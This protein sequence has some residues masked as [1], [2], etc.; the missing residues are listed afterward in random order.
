MID[1]MT[2]ESLALEERAAVHAAL[3]DPARLRIVDLLMLGDLSPSELM[4]RL[5]LASNLL[6]HHLKVLETAGVVARRRSDADRRRTYLRLLPDRLDPLAPG[7]VRPVSRVV[8]VCTAASA[9]SQLAAALWAHSSPVP[10][11]AAGTHP[12]T[13]IA[14]GAAA[15]ARRHGL[16]LAPATPRRLD[17]VLQV[18]DYVITVCDNAHEEL[19]STTSP[20]ATPAAGPALHW[21]VPDPVA[22]GTRAAFDAA[23]DALA[24]RV[25]QLVPHLTAS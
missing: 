22:V 25:T 5:D 24:R 10:A 21:S 3:G 8:F 15:A 14:V 13:Q 7:G 19:G 11:E 23:Y 20:D 4:T 9:R 6:A 2:T 17:Q 16:T 1:S 18:G 12:A